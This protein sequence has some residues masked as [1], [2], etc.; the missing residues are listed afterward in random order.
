MVSPLEDDR[1]SVTSGGSSR[2]SLVD[3]F[4]RRISREV[5][6]TGGS[7]RT[8]GAELVSAVGGSVAAIPDGLTAISNSLQRMALNLAKSKPGAVIVIEPEVSLDAYKKLVK[9]DESKLLQLIAMSALSKE[10]VSHYLTLVKAAESAYVKSM[11]AKE[12]RE[13]KRVLFA[14]HKTLVA[15]DIAVGVNEYDVLPL[16]NLLGHT[17]QHAENKR[18][19][20]YAVTHSSFAGGLET[21][22]VLA[23]A[24]DKIAGYYLAKEGFRVHVPVSAVNN[25]FQSTMSNARWAVE[26]ERLC[27]HE[28]V[29]LGHGQPRVTQS[30]LATVYEAILAAI[31][32]DG[33]ET[34]LLAFN[35][36][37][38][39]L[40]SDDLT[41]DFEKMMRHASPSSSAD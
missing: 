4:S 27:L 6:I 32:I 1:S 36:V 28:F 39:W 41:S 21:N 20:V 38:N 18:L 24:G 14:D 13:M 5:P 8:G 3:F 17:L 37:S 19:F 34:A 16:L 33:G 29:R 31:F 11:R 10:E 25:V 40:C 22:R 12:E 23:L 7:I 9:L 35:D 30:I 2:A 15:D 26:A